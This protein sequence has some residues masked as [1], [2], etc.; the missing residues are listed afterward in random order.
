VR[1]LAPVLVAGLAAGLAAGC[2]SP[3][4]SAVSGPATTAPQYTHPAVSV[5]PASGLR[6]GQ[7]VQVSVSGFGIGGKVFLSECATASDASLLGCGAQLAAQPFVVTGEDRSGS[8]TFTVRASA[9]AV[10][11]DPTHPVPC[12]TGCVLVAVGGGGAYVTAALSFSG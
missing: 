2:G 7:A 3:A 10:P 9:A 8:T 1:V 4:S 12:T 5:A 11:L 6:D